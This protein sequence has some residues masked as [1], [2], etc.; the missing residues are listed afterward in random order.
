M[1]VKNVRV[2][3]EKLVPLAIAGVMAVSMTACGGQVQMKNVDFGVL[4]EEEQIQDVTIIDELIARGELRFDDNLNLLEAADQLDRYM[5][6]VELTDKLDFTGVDQLKPLTSEECAEALGLTPEEVEVLINLSK[7][8]GDDVVQLEQKL[9][10]L[11]KLN[12]LNKT[13]KEW[14][15]ENG[16][17]ICERM[18]MVSI[19]AS[20]A[21]EFGMDDL[22]GVTIPPRHSVSEPEPYLIEVDGERYS[23]P[24]SEGEIWNTINYLYELQGSDLDNGDQENRFK[25]YDKAINFAK[26]TIAAGSNIKNNKLVSQYDA[27]YIEGNFVK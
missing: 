9:D 21:A 25:T 14:V 17:Y 11:K 3:K 26:T 22:G 6:I 18:M 23:I 7:Y 1:G 19:K 4:M 2:F 15:Y 8:K 13:C 5:R 12:Y 16:D 27:G 24:T 10:A 20:V